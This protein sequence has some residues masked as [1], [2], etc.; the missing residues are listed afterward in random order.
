[1]NVDIVKIKD[2]VEGLLDWV[3]DDLVANVAT[4]ESSW[5]YLEFNE[6]TID[7]TNFYTQL[8]K[9]IE[10]GDDDR[11]KLEVRLM[12][13]RD[14]ANLPTFHIHYPSEDGRSG[15]NT[16]NTGFLRVETIGTDNVPIYSRS[17]IGQYELIITG[18]NSLDVVM[19]YEFLDGLLIAA[20]DTLAYY[21]DKFEFSGKQ[22]MAN[23]DIIPYLTFYRAIGLSLQSK[24][25]VRS[26]I[27][28]KKATDIQF[29]GTLYTDSKQPTKL[30]TAVS[31]E[32]Y[33]LAENVG[34]LLSFFAN[35]VNGGVVPE[36]TWY[37]NDV[38]VKTGS[39]ATLDY[40]F[41]QAGTFVFKVEML[42]S[43]QYLTPRLATSNTI[44]V[45][46]T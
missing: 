34:D 9:L 4:P 7:D 32:Y 22:L 40:Q 41:T 27:N 43:L 18:G 45:V 1:M 14:R 23:Q 31:I 29:E 36:Y 12:F 16:L 8:K 19:L 24:K 20:A 25:I 21:F 17:F 26:L 10:T 6:L 38:E 44:S 46:I 33:S 2:I 13:D 35:P 30:G 37:V 42:S 28:K 15:D 39:E 3:R 11:R 5:L